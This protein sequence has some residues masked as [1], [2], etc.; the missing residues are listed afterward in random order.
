MA[1]AHSAVVEIVLRIIIWLLNVKNFDETIEAITNT[2]IN[3]RITP[4]FVFSAPMKRTLKLLNS[5]F[6]VV[7]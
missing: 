2:I 5:L 6:P 3:A 7:I 1:K 4:P